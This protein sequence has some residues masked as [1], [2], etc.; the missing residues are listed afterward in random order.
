MLLAVA[1]VLV[2]VILLVDW[3]RSVA[4]QDR[5]TDGYVCAITAD[6][7]GSNPDC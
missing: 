4:E 5:I 6:R 7:T 2:A 1:I 3:R